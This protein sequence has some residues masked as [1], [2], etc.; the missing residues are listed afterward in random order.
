MTET[1]LKNKIVEANN[2]ELLTEI[3]D[4]YPANYVP[5]LEDE[6]IADE[7]KNKARLWDETKKTFEATYIV[8]ENLPEHSYI[9][10]KGIAKYMESKG[11]NPIDA[12]NEL[13]K[14]KTLENIHEIYIRLFIA[15]QLDL[16]SQSIRDKKIA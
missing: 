15:D 13:G 11:F 12:L 4:L 5:C 9:F 2:L 16:L 14:E 10:I 8:A 1:F 7:L 3:F 6:K